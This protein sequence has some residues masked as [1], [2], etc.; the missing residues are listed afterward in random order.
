MA[1]IK[2]FENRD[3][4]LNRLRDEHLKMNE[5]LDQKLNQMNLKENNGGTVS[6]AEVDEMLNLM[7]A[8]TQD[9]RKINKVAEK[10]GEA[11]DADE[12]YEKELDGFFD[13]YLK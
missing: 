1:V 8:M 6:E 7:A 12:E 10:C 13:E 5:A 11:P 4:K 9:R 3:D 2:N